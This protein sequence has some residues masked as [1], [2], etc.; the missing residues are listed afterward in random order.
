MKGRWSFCMGRWGLPLAVFCAAFTVGTAGA[1][2]HQFNFGGY[3]W[4]GPGMQR[5]A[6]VDSGPEGH[7]FVLDQVIPA[8]KEYDQDGKFI[9]EFGTFGSGNGEFEVPDALAT[10]AEGD[11]WVADTGN[12][13]VDEFS[14][15]GAYLGQFGS[16]EFNEPG[17]IAT[18]AEGDVYVA[19]TRNHRIRKFS[20]E[21]ELIAGEELP[22]WA[23]PTGIAVGPGG[24]IWVGDSKFG[25]LREFTASLEEIRVVEPPDIEHI[26]TVDVDDYGNVWV[27]DRNHYRIVKLDAEG[28]YLDEFGKWSGYEGGNF[29]FSRPFGVD[30]DQHNRIWVTDP[31][32]R[33]V[34]RWAEPVGQV[35]FCEPRTATTPVG[36]PIQLDG[37]ALGCEGEAP[38][39]FEVLEE[40]EHGAISEGL[41][42]A[43]VYTPD[44]EYHG[45]DSILFLARNGLG[46][47]EEML[48]EIEV[49]QAPSCGNQQKGTGEDEALAIELTCTGDFVS[50]GYEI[51]EGP[52]HGEISEFDDEAGTLTYTPNNGYM[53]RDEFT[54]Q[55]SSWVHSASATVTLDVCDAPIVEAWGAVATPGTPG[56][57]LHVEAYPYDTFCPGI[58]SLKVSVDGNVVYSEERDCGRSPF[59][60]Q[61]AELF[62][63]IEVPYSAVV[64]GAH[65]YE[66][67]AT[68][69]LGNRS[70]PLTFERETGEESWTVLDLK[71]EHP[72]GGGCP[73]GP[74]RIGSVLV[75]TKCDDTL[76]P[77]PKA[78]IYRGLEGNDT[79]YGGPSTDTIDGDK[80]E[81][82]IFGARGSDIVKA[83]AE[84]DEV[85]GGSGD[86]VIRGGGGADV[87]DGGPGADKIKGEDG[88][89]LVRGG[90]TTDR[91]FGGEGENTLSYADGV[92]PGF[93]LAVSNPPLV[94][95]FPEKHG[96]R[97]VYVNLAGPE[98]FGD[99]GEAARFGGGADKIDGNFQDV[100][101]TPFD[102]LIVGSN[103]GNVIDG[104]AGEDIVRGGGGTDQIY[105]G[106][107]QDY[108]DGG[109]AASGSDSLEG[110][111]GTGDACVDGT[112]SGTCE[113]TD[114][115]AELI[116]PAEEAIEVG[117][118]NAH[119]PHGESTVYVR[120]STG[121]DHVTATWSAEKITFELIGEGTFEAD[122]G[123][124]V[125]G[126]K[127]ECTG[128]GFTA[129][130]MYGGPGEDRLT[131][132]GF[133]RNIAVTLLG[134]VDADH[135]T[136][137][138]K[139][140]DT[141]VDGPDAANDYL[142]GNNGDDTL[143]SNGG[144]DTLLGG[145]DA[146]LF[147]SASICD[148]DTIRGG[149][150][151]DNA[152]W[153]QLVGEEIEAPGY[154]ATPVDPPYEEVTNGVRVPL[155][156]GAI[157]REE[158]GCNGSGEENGTI[159][160][161]ENLEGSHG[162]DVLIGNGEANVL[163]GRSGADV[164]RGRGGND[165]ILAN[166]RNPLSTA[167]PAEKQ[168]LDLR[169]ECG[170]GEHDVL[171][172]DPADKK[173]IPYRDF[174]GCETRPKDL[175]QPP[176]NYSLPISSG[177]FEGEPGEALDE[178]VIGAA[179]SQANGP[180]AFFRF[181]ETSGSTAADWVNPEAV[182]EEETEEEVREESEEEKE[183]LEEEELEEEEWENWEEEESEEPEEPV[184]GYEGEP[185]LGQAGALEESGSVELDGENDYI[186]LTSDWDPGQYVFNDCGRNVSGY[187][188]EMW[189]K[190]D[191]TPAHLESLFSRTE[192]EEGISLYRSEDG[193]LHFT[194]AEGIGQPTV[195]TAEPIEDSEWHQVVAVMAQRGE[196][197]ISRASVPLVTEEDFETLNSPEMILYVDGF[198]YAL[199]T[200]REAESII[201]QFLSQAHNL[202]GA[203]VLGSGLTD[204]LAGSVD[205][206]AIYGHALSF[207]EVE[208]HLAASDAEQPS[209][210]LRSIPEFF[211]FDEDG[212]PD[213][214]DNCSEVPN[215]EQED[216]DLNGIGD[217][218]EAEADTDEDGVADEVDNCPDDYNPLQED[219]DENG[220]GDACDE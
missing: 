156:Q 178:Q 169:L 106:P 2:V 40:A 195:S 61:G 1:A 124:I 32:N 123:C 199:G 80:G 197:C 146:D 189:V 81:D 172:L 69:D 112:G 83:G 209:A 210:Y 101:G 49:G 181:D 95:G 38:L 76:R 55:R 53:G 113:T 16:G 194:V 110:G 149:S 108:L 115:E 193:K 63:D 162:P 9:D 73:R 116:A 107:G 217:A 44:A 141:L 93:F 127:A 77:N 185:T 109:G 182:E 192:E 85:F 41:G 66:I 208:S 212:V 67:E 79:I 12:N 206:V 155:A 161:V 4:T 118:L 96:E 54:F 21:G 60:C 100:I 59:G 152:N 94:A 125:S 97:G 136:G 42:G 202:V 7:V 114:P 65:E 150:G 39:T 187:S 144:K 220:I 200:G 13:R 188:V 37:A 211:D 22:S 47:S 218:C 33:R 183:A 72:E 30:V 179:Q 20:P 29:D 14:T 168:D 171:K 205:D 173:H 26:D 216:S 157:T 102:D 184:G 6:D 154:P 78:T 129:L 143:F 131:A 137:G 186:D 10:D 75:G 190:F 174:K 68:D 120:G 147:V 103:E 23:V 104:G 87:L 92:T 71:K 24:G 18:D 165:A 111:G 105:G 145:G 3:G 198:P 170:S 176:A 213:S 19:D 62:R 27:G 215:P 128:G 140:E 159:H 51:V 163:L 64:G 48:F 166:N 31:F 58:T 15:N 177:G 34:Q 86:D 5:P 134:G 148:G 167:T 142:K 11:I 50:S 91:L 17:G 151:D 130:T 207:E 90:A 158:T 36:Q 122:P 74:E 214:T 175:V 52:S 8:I 84:N 28:G 121:P 35:A 25:S 132:T 196:G 82:I 126:A 139:S 99:D 57:D 70:E 89:D 153:A 43:L 88:D 201:P 46:E 180:V 191:G 56:V 135:L 117:V 45:S 219:L 204:Y 133:P 119:S 138:S 160:G 98:R 203:R 164:L